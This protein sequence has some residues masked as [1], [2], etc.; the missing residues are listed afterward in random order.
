MACSPRGVGAGSRC[1]GGQSFPDR[2]EKGALNQPGL[3]GP[4]EVT[5]VAVG[6]GCPMGVRR[7]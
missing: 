4:C 7:E 6:L 2:T 1:E 3:G 5:L